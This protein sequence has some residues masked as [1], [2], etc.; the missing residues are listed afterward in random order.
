MESRGPPPGNAVFNSVI[1]SLSKAG[2]M[3]KA[4]KTV[5]TTISLSVLRPS[6]AFT[7]QRVQT[8]NQALTIDKNIRLKDPSGGSAELWQKGH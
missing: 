6:L 7:T 1:N 2:E 3:E 5:L 4:L 8:S